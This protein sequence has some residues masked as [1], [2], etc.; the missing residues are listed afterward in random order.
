MHVMEGSLFDVRFTEQEDFGSE[1]LAHVKRIMAETMVSGDHGDFHVFGA[2][3]DTV[4][5]RRRGREPRR[6]RKRPMSSFRPSRIRLTV[7]LPGLRP[8]QFS[9]ISTTWHPRS[10]A[11]VGN[12]RSR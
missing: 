12:W 1:R 2:S 4:I 3:L 8:P 7:L 10:H 5:V 11:F 9:G 6:R